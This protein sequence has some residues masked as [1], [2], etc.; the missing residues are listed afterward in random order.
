MHWPSTQN[1]LLQIIIMI[2]MTKTMITVLMRSNNEKPEGQGNDL[3]QPSINCKKTFWIIMISMETM[4]AM[5]KLQKNTKKTCW[6][7]HLSS[8]QCRQGRT[9]FLTPWHTNYHYLTHHNQPLEAY[10]STITRHH[11]C[12]H[13]LLR[14]SQSH[15]FFPLNKVLLIILTIIFPKTAPPCYLWRST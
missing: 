1:D 4:L 11:T 9:S 5:E 14:T 10:L 6:N 7:F 2:S 15:T 8:R 3:Q 13:H 12:N